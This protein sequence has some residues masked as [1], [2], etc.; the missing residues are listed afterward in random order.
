[1]AAIWSA[2]NMYLKPGMRGVPSA[3]IPRTTSWLPPAVSRDS[4]GP[5]MPETSVGRVWQTPQCWSTNR[6]PSIWV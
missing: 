6:R 5:Y 2:L 1:M 4:S 3:T